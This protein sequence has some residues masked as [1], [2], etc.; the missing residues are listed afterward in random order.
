MKIKNSKTFWTIVVGIAITLIVIFLSL[1]SYENKTPNILSQEDLAKLVKPAV[2]RIIQHAT[3][4][5]TVPAFN[6]D[7]NN[8]TIKISESLPA[9]TQKIDQ[10]LSGS[11]FVVNSNG[12]ILTNAHV[13]S[14]ET[15]KLL[16]LKNLISD[17]LEEKTKT[18]S[19][20]ELRQFFPSENAVALF[21]QN[22]LDELLSQSTFNLKSQLTVLNPSDSQEFL[23]SLLKT[24]Y[25]AEIISVNENFE[26]DQKDIAVI[27]VNASN[28]PTLVLGDSNNI[29][30]GNQ[31]YAFGFPATAEFNKR[32]PLEA[33]LTKGLISAVKF[34]KNKDFKA[35]QTDAKISEGSSGGPLFNEQGQVVGIIT[36]L[37]GELLSSQGD[38]F[39]FAIPIN[40]AKPVLEQNNISDTE[41]EFSSHFRL[42][43]DFYYQNQCKKALEEFKKAALANTDFTNAKYL[44][45]YETNCQNLIDAGNSVDNKFTESLAWF[46]TVQGFTWF[47]ILGR[48][49][50][51]LLAIWALY[52]ILIR[53][54]RDENQIAYLEL[55]AENEQERRSR[56]TNHLESSGKGLPLPEL[57]LH[58]K[59]R[60][61]LNLPHPRLAEYITEARNIG[62]KDEDIKAEALKAGWSEE[63]VLHTF[64]TLV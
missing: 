1:K 39:A 55:Q 23:T 38:S 60:R 2:V 59:D 3:G 12:Y 26:S 44:E 20:A 14:T 58:A 46:K 64:Q 24:G 7:L 42:G 18:L 43:L 54:K 61:A 11:G 56:L 5:M 29:T 40:L 6:L 13:V 10:Y 15:I 47:V 53:L 22:S 35:F 21:E 37:T 41:S 57:E 8:L 19:D 36:F 49:I 27:K 33:S 32:S 30:V 31:V 51:V 34:S 25:P 17:I 63:E 62:L 16:I 4:E 9:Q 50:L 28:L 45:N 48:V 52:K